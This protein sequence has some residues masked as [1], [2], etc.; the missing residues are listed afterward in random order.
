MMKSKSAGDM[1]IDI[2]IRIILFLSALLCLYPFYYIFIYSISLPSEAAKANF[3]ILP[4]GFSLIN[5]QQLLVKKEIFN[6]ML[7]SV[8][9]TVIGTGLT[10]FCSSLFGYLVTKKELIFRRFFYRTIVITMYLN[11]SLIP[12]YLTYKM[13]HLSNTFFV[14]V[15]PGAV[16]AFFVILIK[17]YIESLPASLEESAMIDGAKY[18]RIFISIILPLCGPILATVAIFAAVTHWNSWQDNFFFVSNSKLKVLQLV[19]WEILNSA[20]TLADSA[21]KGGQVDVSSMANKVS[22]ISI[23]MTITMITTLP[24]ILVYPFLQRYFIK[25]ILIGAVKG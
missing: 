16:S 18:W 13:L 17:T 25:G 19:L 1:G 9:R 3:Y 11:A 7:I 14:Y 21:K 22:P 24:I 4:A 20:Q 10:L 2:I 12:I 15:I 6:S 23:R 8:L 5:Y